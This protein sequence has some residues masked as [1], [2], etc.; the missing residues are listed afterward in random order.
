MSSGITEAERK[1]LLEAV[2]RCAPESMQAHVVKDHL[3][4][5]L[6]VEFRGCQDYTRVSK[7]SVALWLS[8]KYPPNIDAGASFAMLDEM[9]RAGWSV[10]L[11]YIPSDRV[12]YVV[13]LRGNKAS[14][15]DYIRTGTTRAEAI[16]KA[17]IA[18]FQ[19]AAPAD[20]G[21]HHPAPSGEAKE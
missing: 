1:A 6:F 18:C 10:T 12:P 20:E 4:C 14:S 3:G 2:A 16:V 5:V 15:S 8:N 9:E 21:H 7:S 11:D 13:I 19:T 17:F